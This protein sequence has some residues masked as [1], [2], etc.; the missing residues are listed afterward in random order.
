[1]TKIRQCRPD[2]FCYLVYLHDAHIVYIKNANIVCI[3]DIEDAK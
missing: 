1:M 3:G 2:L